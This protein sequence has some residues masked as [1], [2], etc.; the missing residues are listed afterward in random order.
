ML[1][2]HVRFSPEADSVSFGASSETGGFCFCF[3]GDLKCLGAGFGV[4]YY[5]V[6]FCVCLGLRGG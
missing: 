1:E 4:S 2:A 3:D 5:G 6:G